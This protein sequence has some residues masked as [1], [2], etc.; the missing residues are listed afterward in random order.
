MVENPTTLVRVD[1][2]EA[3]KTNI[4]KEYFSNRNEKLLKKLFEHQKITV[5]EIGIPQ[6][7]AWQ[8]HEPNESKRRRIEEDFKVA[9]QEN[10]LATGKEALT[11][12]ELQ[13]A[14]ESIINEKIDIENDKI[15]G[16]TIPA[17]ADDVLPLV[18][19]PKTGNKIANPSKEE[20]IENIIKQT[21]TNTNDKIQALGTFYQLLSKKEN[22]ANGDA[23]AD[24]PE[25][26]KEEIE[27]TSKSCLGR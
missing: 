11:N 6:M 24:S 15:A 5:K 7:T 14:L 16:K 9:L 19:D 13:T 4:M 27:S 20:E 25:D 10:W 21:L 17:H 8:A 23:V 18:D 1:A 3:G 2:E 26:E 12:E 22:E